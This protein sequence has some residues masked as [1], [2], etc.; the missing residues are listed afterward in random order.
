MTLGG[1]VRKASAPSPARAR[2]LVVDDDS[3]VLRAVTR[4]LEG[5]AFEVTAV[6]DSREA[7]RILG[8]ET[9]DAVL[10]DVA[11]PEVTGIELLRAAR[12]KDLEVPVL[13]M[14]GAPDVESAAQAVRHGACAYIAKP[15]A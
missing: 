12:A 1:T 2:I 9:F 3:S 13:L 11:M 6:R 14:T 15:F 7:V 8:C 5:A 4:I 10:T